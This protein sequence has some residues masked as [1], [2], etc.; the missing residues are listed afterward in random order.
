[1]L[2]K[3]KFII[4]YLMI[5]T[6]AGSLNA[7][8]KTSSDNIYMFSSFRDNGKDG[9]YLACLVCNRVAKAQNMATH[10]RR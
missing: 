8:D 4:A 7:A 9:L 5:L 2:K 6:A 3:C 10:R 1:M